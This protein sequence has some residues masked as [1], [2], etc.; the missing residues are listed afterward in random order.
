MSLLSARFERTL[1]KKVF[2]GKNESN[3]ELWGAL[4]KYR[5]QIAHGDASD[6]RTGK[7][8]LLGCKASAQSFLKEA[9]KLLILQ[10]LKEPELISDLKDC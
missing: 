10:G 7:L 1:D 9:A 2:F 3:K 8:K 4:Y 5:S 6:F